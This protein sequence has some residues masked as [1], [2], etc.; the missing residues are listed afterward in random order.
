VT[1]LWRVVVLI[2]A[3]ICTGAC[4]PHHPL[5]PLSIDT[6]PTGG[7]PATGGVSGTG[8]AR[9]PGLG[10][11]TGTGGIIGTGGQGTGGNR[12]QGGSGG[13]SIVPTYDGCT[14]HDCS[15]PDVPWDGDRYTGSI[16][17]MAL[18]DGRDNLHVVSTGLFWEHLSHAGP[19]MHGDQTLPTTVTSALTC[20]SSWCPV[21]ENGCNTC[22]GTCGE[23]RQQSQS[24]TFPL[25]V[26]PG[27]IV[28]STFSCSGRG[29]CTLLQSPTA[30]NPEA[31]IELDDVE[32]PG[33]STYSV[34]LAYVC[35]R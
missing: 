2:V 7:S 35:R 8:G 4:T 27:T 11:A 14:T 26:F 1:G 3:P 24:L 23:L 19:G 18:I 6:T 33:P 5:T 25:T 17:V 21:W 22:D 30:D 13:A 28:S 20:N 31:I 29:R 15:V 10:G 9:V 32:P 34:T 12:G 16:T